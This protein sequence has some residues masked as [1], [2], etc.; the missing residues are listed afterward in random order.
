M[1][2]EILERIRRPSPGGHVME[3]SLPVIAFGDPDIARVATISLN[4][5]PREFKDKRGWLLGDTRRLHSLISLERHAPQDLTDDEVRAVVEACRGYFQGNWFKAWF[6]WLERLLVAARIGSYLDGTACHLDLVQ[7]ATEPAMAGL[8]SD[9]WARLVEEDLPFLR[10][11]LDTSNVDIVLLN[12]ASVVSGVRQAGLVEGFESELLANPQGN[13][14]ALRVHRAVS[15]GRL[16]LGWNKP[17]VGPMLPIQR[18]QLADW[19]GSQITDWTAPTAPPQV[20]LDTAPDYIPAGATVSA[21]E[22]APLLS[23]WAARSTASTIG[24]VGAFGGRA[25]VTVTT[26]SGPFA[27]NADT[28]RAAVLEYLAAASRHEVAF[29]VIANQRGRINRVIFRADG[30]PTPGWYAYTAN[31]RSRVGPL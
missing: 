27:L 1:K 4:P 5:S 6:G 18:Q 28:K 2:P 13:G 19:I 15:G 11:Q 3:G 23:E 22:L 16:Y 7:W 24:D 8:P 25:L 9:E 26:P 29:H 17:A 12:S 20:P 10:W 30:Q 21:D 31:E 14:T